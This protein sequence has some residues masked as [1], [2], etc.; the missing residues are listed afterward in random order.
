LTNSLPVDDTAVERDD[1]DIIFE[2]IAAMVLPRRYY[3]NT[4]PKHCVLRLLK[5]KTDMMTKS[6]TLL[7]T[8]AFLVMTSALTLWLFRALKVVLNSREH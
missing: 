8:L 1:L 2:D 3:I 7:R 6:P 4:F 5:H